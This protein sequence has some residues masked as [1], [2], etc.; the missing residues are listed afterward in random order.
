MYRVE[1]DIE[2]MNRVEQ[3][4]EDMYRVKQDLEDILKSRAIDIEEEQNM[5]Y[6]GYVQNRIT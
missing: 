2:D 1:Q 6:I 5:I 3:D 4:I